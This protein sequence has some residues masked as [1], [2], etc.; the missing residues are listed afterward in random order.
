MTRSRRDASRILDQHGDPAPVSKVSS[1]H[2]LAEGRVNILRANDVPT[3]VLDVQLLL[4]PTE[5]SAFVEMVFKELSPYHTNFRQFG[6]D[7]KGLLNEQSLSEVQSKV[8]V[9]Q[10]CHVLRP[11]SITQRK[12]RPGVCVKG[13]AKRLT[14]LLSP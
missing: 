8:N 13:G 1:I 4:L 11:W 9:P 6:D 14:M 5:V 12:R 7:P 2:H 10:G 3:L